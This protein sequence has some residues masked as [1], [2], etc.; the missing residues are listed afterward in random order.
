M[1]YFSL[2]SL[3]NYAKSQRPLPD[4][5]LRSIVKQLAEAINYLHKLKIAHRDIK[6]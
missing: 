3:V 1:E 5:T 6:P 4:H 2:T